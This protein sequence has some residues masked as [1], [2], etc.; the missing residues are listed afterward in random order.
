MVIN[1]FWVVYWC[2]CYLRV[3]RSLSAQLSAG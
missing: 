2:T 1:G 3:A